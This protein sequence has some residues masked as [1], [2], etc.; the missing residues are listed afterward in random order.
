MT[1]KIIHALAKTVAFCVFFLRNCTQ[2][3]ETR[4]RRPWRRL[5]RRG[6]YIILALHMLVV[7][8]GHFSAAR[9][10]GARIGTSRKGAACSNHVCNFKEP[11][12][13]LTS[14]TAKFVVSAT[15]A[16]E[17]RATTSLALTA[18][19]LLPIKRGHFGCR[20]AWHHWGNPSWNGLK[21][22]WAGP[23]QSFGPSS[24]AIFLPLCSRRTVIS[25]YSGLREISSCGLLCCDLF[26]STP[27]ALGTMTFMAGIPT[28][29]SGTNAHGPRRRAWKPPAP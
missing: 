11:F 7:A 2:H 6:A 16:P 15:L 22:V 14:V 9:V 29:W 25:T 20:A 27:T 21:N 19:T 3:C 12:A 28:R 18:R 13:A 1:I 23:D 4:L 10:S 17:H 5:L 8:E 24:T 26:F